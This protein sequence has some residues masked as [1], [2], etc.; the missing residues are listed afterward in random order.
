MEKHAEDN[1]AEDDVELLGERLKELRNLRKVSQ[2][3][4]AKLLRVGQT[5]LSHAETRNDMKL[6]TLLEYVRAL[7]GRLEVA[8]FFEDLGRRELLSERAHKAVKVDESQLT[9]PGFLPPVSSVARD[10]VLSIKPRY[11]E[12]ILD[13][14]KTV[15]LRRRFSGTVPSGARAWIYSTTPT[16]AMTG[17]ATITDVQRLRLPEIWKKHKGAAALNKEEFEAY[18]EGVEYGYAILLSSPRMFEKPISLLNLRLLC[19]F[20]PP[21]SYQYAPPQLRSLVH[22]E[23]AEAPN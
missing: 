21:Q 19:D 8:A 6:S 3:D 20:E 13:G 14:T 11:A 12:K 10:V 23:W 2:V 22:G 9:L 7:G 18:F 15:E 5:A 4:L 16:K 17:S 1:A